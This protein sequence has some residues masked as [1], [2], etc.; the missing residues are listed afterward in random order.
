MAMKFKAF[1]KGAGQP[2]A[3]A[4]IA[5]NMVPVFGTL[6]LGWS[7]AALIFLFWIENIILGIMNIVKLL[8]IKF[9]SQ[10]ESAARN[11]GG[12]GFITL[13][14]TVHY[15]GFCAA[16]ALLV[17]ILIAA[18]LHIEF[19]DGLPRGY[20]I[21]VL[22]RDKLV[23]AP[24]VILVSHLVSLISNWFHKKERYGKDLY[25]VMMAPYSRIVALSITGIIGAIPIMMLRSPVAGLILLLA[26]KTVMDLKAHLKERERMAPRELEE[27]VKA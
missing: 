10:G 27:A 2:S 4:L 6:F 12:K 22:F 1:F 8:T 9:D 14:F 26:I 21:D 5:A 17:M 7:V 3:L 16:H 11:W 24:A 20:F 23:Y 13:F 19:E 25:Q 15:G 18:A